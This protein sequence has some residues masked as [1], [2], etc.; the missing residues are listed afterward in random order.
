MQL[1]NYLI[2][3]PYHCDNENQQLIQNGNPGLCSL[4]IN[5]EK[6]TKNRGSIMSNAKK[7]SLTRRKPFKI[8]EHITLIECNI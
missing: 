6:L 3:M 2:P 4:D 7:N 8:P 5:I 1:V